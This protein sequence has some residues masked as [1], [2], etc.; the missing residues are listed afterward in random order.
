MSQVGFELSLVTMHIRDI[1]LAF[2]PAMARNLTATSHDPNELDELQRGRRWP[3]R[4]LVAWLPWLSLLPYFQDES[5]SHEKG[6]SDHSIYSR[7]NDKIGFQQPSR[8]VQGIG[9]RP[10]LEHGDDRDAVRHGDTVGL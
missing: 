1:P 9:R 5:V 8:S 4:Y 3:I 2:S 6:Q 10:D 7:A